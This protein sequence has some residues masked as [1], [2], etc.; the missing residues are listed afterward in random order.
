MY[1]NTHIYLFIINNIYIYVYLMF[2]NCINNKEFIIIY[3]FLSC[4]ISKLSNKKKI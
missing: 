4:K 3:A 2:R 1:N